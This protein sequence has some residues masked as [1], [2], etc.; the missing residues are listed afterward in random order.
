ME[1]LVEL[2]SNA[3]RL[4]IVPAGEKLLDRRMAADAM[5]G[6]LRKVNRVISKVLGNPELFYNRSVPSKINDGRSAAARKAF[7]KKPGL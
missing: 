3:K 5:E 2:L 7:R 6:I 4:L 1:L